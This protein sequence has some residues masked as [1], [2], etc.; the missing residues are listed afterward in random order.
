MYT[1]TDEQQL[2]AVNRRCR[3]LELQLA[4]STAEV[5]ALKADREFART[6]GEGYSADLT[7]WSTCVHCDI[8]CVYREHK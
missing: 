4:A 3:E 1:Y 2:I 5:R 8:P 7:A 6:L